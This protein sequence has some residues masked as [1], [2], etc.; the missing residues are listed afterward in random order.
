M[1]DQIAPHPHYRQPSPPLYGSTTF[2]HLEENSG[3]VNY[4]IYVKKQRENPYGWGT[5]PYKPT[6]PKQ[7]V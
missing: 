6:I 5:I 7:R 4:H 3:V 1:S 2:T